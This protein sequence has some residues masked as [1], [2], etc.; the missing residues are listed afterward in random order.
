MKLFFSLNIKGVIL[1]AAV[2]AACL[3]T[4]HQFFLP[5]LVNSYNPKNHSAAQ[6][7]QYRIIP[8]Y[9]RTMKKV[10][11]SLGHKNTSLKL[12]T[13]II[14][15]FP[16]YTKIFILTPQP[17][18]D[19]VN[20]EVQ[21]DASLKGRTHIVPYE[22]ILLKETSFYFLFP[23]KEK[24]QHGDTANPEIP[25]LFGSSWAQD[26]F[27]VAHSPS[28]QTN[29]LISSVHKYYFSP[30]GKYD[31]QVRRDNTYIYNLSSP[32][33]HVQTIP[34]AF[35]GGNILIDELNGKRIAFCG[36][37]VLKRTKTVWRAV[38][39]KTIFDEQIFTL[40]KNFLHVDKVVTLGSNAVQPSLMFH[41]DQ[42]VLFLPGNI[43]G[44]A[45]IVNLGK[46]DTPIDN[47]ILAAK[48][49]LRKTRSRLA[50]LGYKIV[51]IK[52][53]ASGLLHYQHYANAI[54]YTDAATGERIILM[55]VF[56]SRQN[57]FDR[58]LIADNSRTL[59]EIGY[60]IIP[61]PTRANEINGGIHCLVN[62]L[63]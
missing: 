1:A 25:G 47:D 11:I 54:P 20:Q 46:D 18:L 50:K 12:H 49:F 24:L 19:L 35:M 3:I 33:M 30:K 37:D 58:K 13:N 7:D 43:A 32:G 41:L 53:S 2:F 9:D 14:K 34:I 56:P 60:K 28:G 29:L 55:P 21:S 23:E 40:I 52:M 31:S 6:A 22:T 26:L 63:E 27:E 10:V 62:V 8:E 45:K 17:Y 5:R 39:G 42:A 51:D 38:N 59:Q 16:D 44:V 15:H 4:F 36:S 48:K 61:V 57:E